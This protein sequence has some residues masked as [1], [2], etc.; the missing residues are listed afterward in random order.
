M[1]GPSKIL[2]STSLVLWGI[3][4]QLGIVT[5]AQTVPPT[6]PPPQPIWLYPRMVAPALGTT[7]TS[8]EISVDSAGRI[9]FK[10]PRAIVA[11]FD[12]WSEQDELLM[13]TVLLT[14]QAMSLAYGN[15]LIPW[16]P[17]TGASG[18]RNDLRKR[19]WWLAFPTVSVGTV[20][21]LGSSVTI[22]NPPPPPGQFSPGTFTTNLQ[23][24]YSLSWNVGAQMFQKMA[25][26]D[27]LDARLSN[28]CKMRNEALKVLSES[29]AARKAAQRQLRDAL[30]EILELG[31]SNSD[32]TKDLR[33]TMDAAWADIIKANSQ[34]DLSTLSP[35]T[36]AGA[37][38]AAYTRY[39]PFVPTF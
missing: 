26:R 33:K 25:I 4:G 11:Y 29:F 5:F 38:S 12:H 8:S 1:N 34:I 31:N 14:Q 30:I 15:Y 6:P 37:A 23:T 18:Y 36:P 7:S 22:S 20:N 9:Q 39:S 19:P 3:V 28:E 16:N 2:L 27:A 24:T 13:P 17:T 32:R 10:T 21:V 35:P